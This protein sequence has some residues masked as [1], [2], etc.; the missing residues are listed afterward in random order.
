M[1][2]VSV[3]SLLFLVLGHICQSF[4]EPFLY[5]SLTIKLSLTVLPAFATPVG[6]D[7][8][9]L[10]KRTSDGWGVKAADLVRHPSGIKA[11]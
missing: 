7:A 9:M 5:S 8:P 6:Q 11:T 4:H 3:L 2:T 10:R 1:R